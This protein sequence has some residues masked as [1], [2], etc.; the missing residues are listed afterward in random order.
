MICLPLVSYI[1]AIANHVSGLPYLGSFMAAYFCIGLVSVRLWPLRR[2]AAY[3]ASSPLVFPA[4]VGALLPPYD[5]DI[6]GIFGR[7]KLLGFAAVVLAA[8]VA[9][10]NIFA[11]QPGPKKNGPPPPREPA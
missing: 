2:A 5:G 11:E 1:S 9:P 3:A 4:I 10:Y 7:L 6:E 8:C